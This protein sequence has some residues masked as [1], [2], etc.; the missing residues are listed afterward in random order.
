MLRMRL[1]PIIINNTKQNLLALGAHALQKTEKFVIL[2][3]RF[4]NTATKLY[5]GEL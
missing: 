4:A 2:R 5:K 3:C 1:V